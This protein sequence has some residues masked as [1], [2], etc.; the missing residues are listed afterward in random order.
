MNMEF[1]T[2]DEIQFINAFRRLSPDDQAYVA[3]LFK[4]YETGEINSEELMEIT[5]NEMRK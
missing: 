4:R 2:P 3:D 1:L 5:N